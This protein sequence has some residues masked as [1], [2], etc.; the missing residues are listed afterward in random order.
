MHG[1]EVVIERPFRDL[2]AHPGVT[3]VRE[4]VM[5]GTGDAPIPPEYPLMY[6]GYGGVG[7]L[8][9]R[10]KFGIDC[11]CAFAEPGKEVLL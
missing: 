6:S 10:P 7:S 8:A 5:Q 11:R 2:L 4:P 3:G 1:A 9:Q